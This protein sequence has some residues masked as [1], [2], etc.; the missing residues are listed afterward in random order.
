VATQA[1][2]RAAQT[3]R[4]RGNGT[5][6]GF[7]RHKRFKWLKVA[8]ALSLTTILGYVLVDVQP[9]P[10]GGSWYGYALGTLGALLILW[11][12]LL[13]VRKRAITRGRYSL[14]SWTSAHVYLGLSL[15]VVAT[16]HT[17]FQFG[18]NVHTLAYALMMLVIFSG[19]FGIVV[20][21]ILPRVMSA[22]RN[23]MT[24]AQMLT[25]LRS[26]DRQLHDAAQPLAH[27]QAELVRTSLEQDPFGGGIFRR[28]SG[29]YPNCATRM[30]QAEIRRETAYKPNVG[31]DPAEKVDGLLERKEAILARVRRHL[32]L[33]AMLE[34]W[35]YVHVPVTF[36]LIAALAAH[37]IS[38]FFYW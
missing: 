11:L 35:L 27:N 26:I 22:N 14:K 28:L 15:I 8:V 37:I 17:G 33:K 19:I 10:N 24:E 5:H 38:V 16:L 34:V 12:T 21:S 36:A 1:P 4:E 9:R 32:R 3:G 23:E 2:T 31:N 18:L 20:Y 7:L 30:A 13:G 25:T 6:D 29:R